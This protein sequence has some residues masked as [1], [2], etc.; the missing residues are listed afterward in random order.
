VGIPAS[1]KAH[2]TLL[3]DRQICPRHAEGTVRRRHLRSLLLSDSVNF[4][5]TRDPLNVSLLTEPPTRRD[6]P[7]ITAEPSLLSASLPSPPSACLAV[8]L[9]E[10]D[11]TGLLR[12]LRCALYAGGITVPCRQLGDLHPDHILLTQG[13]GLQ[14][15]NP[16]RSVLDDNAYRHSDPLTL[17]SVPGP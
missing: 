6:I 16:R 2:F 11:E 3:P 1:P 10:D 4:H 12:S 8:S 5:V 7:T 15:I 13:S 14:R 17:S 9:P